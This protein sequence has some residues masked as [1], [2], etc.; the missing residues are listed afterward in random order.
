MYKSAINCVFL[1]ICLLV[2]VRSDNCEDISLQN[3]CIAKN[4]TVLNLKNYYFVEKLSSEIGLLVN[5]Q[6]LTFGTDNLMGS[7]PT[8][9]G[10]L[11][12]LIHLDIRSN[13]IVNIPT[14]IGELKSLETFLIQSNYISEIPTELGLLNNLNILDMSNNN[15]YYLPD[16]LSLLN[17]LTMLNM[18]FNKLV[19]IPSS[20]GKMENL[21]YLDVSYNFLEEIPSEMGKLKKLEILNLEQNNIFA[22]P[23]ELAM[24]RSLSKVYLDY[25]LLDETIPELNVRDT[26]DLSYNFIKYI[27]EMLIVN[28]IFLLSHNDFTEFPKSILKMTNLRYLDISNNPIGYLPTDWS[29]SNLVVGIFSNMSLI[30]VTFSNNSFPKLRKIDMS[31]N[32]LTKVDEALLINENIEEL[33]MNNN[34]ITDMSMPP[35]LVIA[36]FS[37]N[38]VHTLSSYVAR[39]LES[40]DLS[41]NYLTFETLTNWNF[42]SLNI[43]YPSLTISYTNLCNGVNCVEGIDRDLSWLTLI[44]KYSEIN[45][46]NCNVTGTLP[47][48][49]YIYYILSDKSYISK[50]INLNYNNL[51][52]KIPSWVNAVQYFTASNNKFT[53]LD[54][55]K[56]I[57]NV[58][59]EHL[60]L[61]SNKINY[62]FVELFNNLPLKNLPNFMDFS[63]NYNYGTL[64]SILKYPNISFTAI[65]TNN[66][67]GPDCF[68]L[69][70]WCAGYDWG[71]NQ[72]CWTCNKICG[73]GILILPEQCDDNNTINGDGC[74]SECTIEDDWKCSSSSINNT[75]FIVPSPSNCVYNKSGGVSTIIII[76]ITVIPVL[77]LLSII[78]GLTV[79]LHKYRSFMKIYKSMFSRLSTNFTID[80]NNIHFEKEIGSGKYGKVYKGFFQNITTVA[81]KEFIK[82]EDGGKEQFEIFLEEAKLMCAIPSHPNLVLLLGICISATKKTIFIVTEFINNGSLFNFLQSSNLLDTLSLVKISLCIVRGMHHLSIHSII[83]NDLAARNVLVEAKIYDGSIEYIA[84][85][86]DFGLATAKKNKL[87]STEKRLIPIRWTAQ[88]ILWSNNLPSPKSDVWSFGVVLYEIFTQCKHIPYHEIDNEDLY[89]YIEMQ[90]KRLPQ[91]SDCPDSIYKVM[92]SCFIREPDIR[93]SFLNLYDSLTLE[94]LSLKE[95]PKIQTESEFHITSKV[96]DLNEE[97]GFVPRFYHPK[98][99]DNIPHLTSNNRL[100]TRLEQQETSYLSELPVNYTRTLDPHNDSNKT[101]YFDNQ[102]IVDNKTVTI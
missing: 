2:T 89:N 69:P 100:Q 47:D 56:I 32:N 58:K 21:T 38:K 7:I 8:E 66:I 93:P 13:S 59:L 37:Y 80:E 18:A 87:I 85:V 10:N 67:P 65:F 79:Y 48:E 49:S 92:M 6:N 54:L 84:K 71:G 64:P 41:H 97:Q 22:I 43:L 20:I 76:I 44:T 82:D 70:K 83:H 91:P 94:S 24:L 30:D 77:F 39:R 99:D 78:L 26:L 75:D 81:I 3:Y 16:Q 63:Y 1:W 31:Y 55:N 102:N 95:N 53:A 33:I 88:E 40:I 17:S 51:F 96:G 11:K 60:D 73:D 9:I 68:L 46:I 5:L 101:I 86:A 4:E 34:I 12:N 62:S 14:E 61:S 52:G 74:S 50:K 15:I 45:M 27:P 98:G 25:N 28:E 90:G 57:L 29:S 35:N 36:D 23:T 19:D 72:K 42:T